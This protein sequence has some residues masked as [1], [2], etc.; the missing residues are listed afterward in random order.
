[1]TLSA[2][3]K[4]KIKKHLGEHPKSTIMDPFIKVLEDGADMEAELVAALNSC[5]T[6]LTAKDTVET[7]ADEL[8]EGGGAKFNYNR[9]L[10]I[11]KGAYRDA[12]CNLARIIGWPMPQAGKVG[13]YLAL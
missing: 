1:M 2:A 7:S 12:V 9:S 4:L 6:A 5:D 8:T 10:A 11:K 13:G 3:Q